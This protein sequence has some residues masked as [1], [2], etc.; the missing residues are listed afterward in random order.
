M[1]SPTKSIQVKIDKLRKRLE[2]KWNINIICIVECG[3]RAYGLE[4]AT[5]DY[6]IRFIYIQKDKGVYKDDYL[7]LQARQNRL[8]RGLTVCDDVMQRTITNKSIYPDQTEIDYH[9]WD[10]TKAIKHLNEMNGS[11]VEWVYS[12]IVY[13]DDGEFLKRAQQLLCAQ[14]RTYPIQN[15][16]KGMAMSHFKDYLENEKAVNIKKYMVCVRS[17]I[18]YEWIEVNLIESWQ[19]LIQ[20]DFRK[21]LDDLEPYLDDGLLK[22]VRCLIKLKKNKGKDEFCI[23][24][25]I[26]DKFIDEVLFKSFHDEDGLEPKPRG[27]NRLLDHYFLVNFENLQF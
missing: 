17:C 14:N 24:N 2:K 15:H 16:Y 7:D 3:S 1:S 9:G 5:S 20:V 11:I 19:P 25:K 18:M 23:K 4:S 22:T 26:L 12:P 6:D 10:I 13:F 27:F 21:V 8:Q